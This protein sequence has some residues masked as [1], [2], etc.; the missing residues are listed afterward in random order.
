MFRSLFAR[1]LITISLVLTVSFLILSLILANFAN[2]YELE[3][4]AKDLVHTAKAA[5]ALTEDI[6]LSEDGE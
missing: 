2:E 5:H 4:Y 6:L 1:M 3:R